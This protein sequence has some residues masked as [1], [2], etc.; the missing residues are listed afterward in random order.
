MGLFSK[1]K[2]TALKADV[3]PAEGS[4]VARRVQ[5][6]ARV[7]AAYERAYARGDMGRMGLLEAEYDA[8][9]SNL[10]KEQAEIAE[11]LGTK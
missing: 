7:K 3:N 5:R 1:K 6:V 2:F 8:I 4:S 10:V 9:T 11:I